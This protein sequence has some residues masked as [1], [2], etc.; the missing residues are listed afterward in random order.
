[1]SDYNPFYDD[2]KER[3]AMKSCAFH[4]VNG[5]K[6]KRCTLPSD[7][8]TPAQKRKLN[9]PVKEYELHKRM[10]YHE[11]KKMPT[12]LQQAHLDY[13]QRRFRIGVTTISTE[14]FELSQ[15]GLSYYM[16]THGLELTQYVG[17]R[18]SNETREAIRKWKSGAE[19]TPSAPYATEEPTEAVVVDAPVEEAPVAEPAPEKPVKNLV[20]ENLSAH[21]S[22]TAGDL[23]S[24]I[25]A[26]LSGR[27]ADV[28]IEL[29]FKE[30]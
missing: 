18:V 24:Y 29:N 22:G 26:M 11:F 4:K 20:V 1:M 7:N 16:K 28:R 8:L 21:I 14:V 17:K 25:S 30:E 15:Y 9:G 2:V 19:D 3:N 10:T 6:S 5:S 12:D 13:I 27:S 23:L